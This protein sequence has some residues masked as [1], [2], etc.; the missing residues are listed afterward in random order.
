MSSDISE[1]RRF[2]HSQITTAFGCGEK[3]RRTYVERE[4]RRKSIL[5]MRRGSAVHKAAEHY[6]IEIKE[7]RQ[8]SPEAL[9]EV[10]AETL[11]NSIDD[12]VTDINDD[13]DLLKSHEI[14]GSLVDS[15]IENV[16]PT[17][18][19]VEQVEP[20]L[21]AKIEID[22]VILELEGYP[23]LI[24]VDE[25][26]GELRV[27]DYKTGK[28]FSA[29]TYESGL[30]LPMYTLLASA[31]GME[32]S[33]SRIDH[34]RHL[35]SGTKHETLELLRGPESH[36]RLARVVAS[37]SK[38]MDAKAFVPNPTSWMCNPGCDYW[39]SCAFRKPDEEGPR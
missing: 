8:V 9:R 5:A 35:K 39:A 34:L 1:K 29:K 17:I 27:R 24:D 36:I 33:R 7:Q 12:S 15:W 32:T 30:Q 23:D 25:A 26:T 20:Y 3:F 6:A 16:A 38:Y 37:V 28:T 4:P 22:G 21:T 11:E 10:A 18:T 31:N 13:P 2:S 14:V 19:H